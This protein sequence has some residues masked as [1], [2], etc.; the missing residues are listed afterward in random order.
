MLM[1]MLMLMLMVCE[2]TAVAI[3]MIVQPSVPQQV[4]CVR[5]QANICIRT[6]LYSRHIPDACDCCSAASNILRCDTKANHA[7]EDPSM[8]VNV[9]HVPTAVVDQIV[10]HTT[11]H[12]LQ[13]EDEW[14][15]V[16]Y[17][18][19][20]LPEWNTRA[21][22]TLAMFNLLATSESMRVSTTPCATRP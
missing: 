6:L 13:G 1:L 14:S 8:S 11:L 7:I 17:V 19:T 3:L 10:D 15:G 12:K 9:Q 18:C 16:T 21:T 22:G 4:Q 5:W 2:R 20:T